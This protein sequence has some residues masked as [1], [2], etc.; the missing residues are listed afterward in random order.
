[1]F[2]KFSL[3]Q[4]IE[5]FKIL[6]FVTHEPIENVRISINNRHYGYSDK[7]GNF[8]VNEKV[9]LDS[10]GLVHLNY[11]NSTIKKE[12]LIK[13]SIYLYPKSEALN[14]VEID[15]KKQQ[16]N[17]INLV[18]K[19]GLNSKQHFA[20]N[21][22]AITYIPFK[23]EGGITKLKYKLTNIAGVK[24]LKYLEFKTNLYSIDSIT[25]LPGKQLIVKDIITSNSNGDRI[26]SL[27]ISEYNIQ[28]PKD[29][30]FI[31]FIVL[32]HTE[33]PVSSIMSR[34]G[35]L[36]ATPVLKTRFRKKNEKRFSMIL[37]PEGYFSKTEPKWQKLDFNFFLMDLELEE[38]D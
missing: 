26:Y 9:L 19:L 3:G 5:N 13:S 31:A 11:D 25:R 12:K 8:F 33:Y 37:T 23:A 29:G 32:D 35:E 15:G 2:F 21:S 34:R 14:K 36:C 28:M 10:I 24:G 17:T 22:K 27:D 4:Q 1:M 16:N 6:D 7:E 30:V 20:W 18:G 38:N